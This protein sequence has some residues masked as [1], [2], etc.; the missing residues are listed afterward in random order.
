MR[1]LLRLYPRIW[2][3]RY[4]AEVE[5]MLSGHAFSLRVAIDLMAGAIDT[6]LHPSATLA[7]AVAA[8]PPTIEEKHMLARIIRFDCAMNAKLS[9]EDHWKSAISLVGITIAL[10]LAWIGVRRMTGDNDMV[11]SMSTMPFMFA[12]LYSMR[13]TYLKDRSASVQAMFIGGLTL[14]CVLIL[15]TAGWISAQI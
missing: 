2:R 14:V 8:A 15:L 12:T 6:R 13:Y 1:W 10:T 4:G 9:R 3:E 5:D 11:A 7:A